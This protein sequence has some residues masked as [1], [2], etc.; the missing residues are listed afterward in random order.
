[1]GRKVART[2]L[3]VA[4][5]A[6]CAWGA[7]AAPAAAVG[8]WHVMRL[9]DN[10][11]DDVS[12]AIDGRTLVWE[13]GHGAGAEIWARNLVTGA[14]SRITNNGVEDANPDVSDRFMVWERPD[15]SDWDIFLRDRHT[16]VVQNIS[17]DTDDDHFPRVWGNWVVWE[18]DWPLMDIQLYNILWGTSAVISTSPGHDLLG[19]GAGRVVAWQRGSHNAAE[20]MLYDVYSGI[21][22]QLTLNAVPDSTG[23]TDGRLVAWSHWDGVDNE[24]VLHD[25]AT[26][27]ETTIT[28]NT[29]DDYWPQVDGPW[30]V[31]V[32][33]DGSNSQIWAKNLVSGAVTQVTNTPSEK[34]G[35]RIS[36]CRIVW[37]ESDGSDWEVY[38]AYYQTF[39]DVGPGHAAYDAIENLA[40]SGIISGFRGGLFVPDA[41]VKRA[42]YAK[43]IVGALGIPVDE[44][45]VAPFSDL[46]PDDP[47]DLYPHD[48]IA[49]AAAAGVVKGVGGGRYAPWADVSRA[50]VVT[51]AMRG[52][53][54]WWPVQLVSPPADW[55][56][57]LGMFDPEHGAYM[58][59]AEYLGC[60]DGVV[61]FGP[62]WDPWAPATRA[63]VA[64]IMWGV[65]RVIKPYPVVPTSP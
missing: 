43:M 27:T 57:T 37:Y 61:G 60:L 49:A 45:L 25:I 24:I 48:Y 9:T 36:G 63:E 33:E 5:L 42:Q 34:Q 8:A 1:M 23:G 41:A 2:A 11:V 56:G 30:L 44:S 22:A 13:Q 14:V 20:V 46:G 53:T 58:R 7:T 12:P 65:C 21:T 3:L 40:D 38:C 39:P 15:G 26:G 54:G 51:M 47:T 28:N 6:L 18:H 19:D 31:W 55:P 10:V 17:N 64:Q 50:Q 52:A 32:R 35:L 62:G 16:G 4:A 59:E 29:V